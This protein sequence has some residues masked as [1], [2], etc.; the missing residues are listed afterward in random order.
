LSICVS[1]RFLKPGRVSMPE[2]RHDFCSQRR[3]RSIAIVRDKNAPM[4]VAMIIT[5]GT[6]AAKPCDAICRPRDG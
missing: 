1:E 6:T 4:S 3:K 2:F 5:S